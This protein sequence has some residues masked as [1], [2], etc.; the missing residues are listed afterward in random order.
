MI[1][2]EDKV[3]IVTERLQGSSMEVQPERKDHV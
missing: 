3:R 2:A 1:S